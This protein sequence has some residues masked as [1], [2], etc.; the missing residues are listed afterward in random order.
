MT[1][2]TPSQTVGPF[3]SIGLPYE[4][5]PEVVPPDHP[6]AIR[7][8]GRVFDGD[9]EIVND[10]LIE[11]WQ[12]NP[13]GRYDHPEDTREEIALSDGFHGFGRS[14]TDEEGGY[15]IVTVKPGAVPHPDGGLQAPHIEVAVFAR[16]VLKMLV[17]RLYFPDEAEANE[18]DPVLAAIPA[19]RRD[20]LVARE[21]GG[22]LVFDIRLQ[23]E[24]ET[25][26]F[27]V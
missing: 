11:T 20:A 15:E 18:A 22:R 21:E 23:G 9:G 19:E 5:G 12:A 3:F 8:G 7:V 16:G 1:L 2:P 14:P 10:A 27:D 17:T 26:F 25:P 24:G 6:D 4:G 13:A